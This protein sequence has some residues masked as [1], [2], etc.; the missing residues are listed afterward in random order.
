MIQLIFIYNKNIQKE[1]RNYLLFTLLVYI[2][3]FN[4]KDVYKRNN[5]KN[6]I[7]LG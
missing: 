1:L 2:H 7:E 4:G 6:I 3:S 5:V